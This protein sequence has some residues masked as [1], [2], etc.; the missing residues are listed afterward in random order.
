MTS[1]SVLKSTST[2][3]SSASGSPH[4]K[5]SCCNSY[6]F[7][8]FAKPVSERAMEAGFEFHDSSLN[9]YTNPDP[10]AYFTDDSSSIF[11]SSLSPESSFD[12]MSFVSSPTHSTSST[13]SPS[14]SN[15]NDVSCDNQGAST[16]DVGFSKYEQVSE[17]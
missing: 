4:A 8:R 2:P 17:G 1:V 5:L 11:H 9:L 12:G 10:M 6:S 13:I 15:T 14:K 16:M 7:E 3:N